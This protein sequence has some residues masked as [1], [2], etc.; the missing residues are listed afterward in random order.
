M[1]LATYTGVRGAGDGA[2]FF[3]RRVRP[4]LIKHCYECHSEQAGTREGDLLLDRESGGLQ[5]GNTR[6]GGRSRRAPVIPPDHRH[7][8]YVRQFADAV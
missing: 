6:E 1:S 2:E 5:G 8:L 7:Q 4:L 3:E